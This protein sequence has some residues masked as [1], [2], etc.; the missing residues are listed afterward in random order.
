MFKVI[1]TSV[2]ALFAMGHSHSHASAEFKPFCNLKAIY[3]GRPCEYSYGRMQLIL[4]SLGM[5]NAGG[6]YKI[7]SAD[8][9]LMVFQTT[10]TDASK[11]NV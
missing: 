2:L 4:E 3:P 7:V 1:A 9:H 8:P 5:D 11:E 10:R 6:S